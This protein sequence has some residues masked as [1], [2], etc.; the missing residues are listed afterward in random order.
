MKD[1]GKDTLSRLKP[2]DSGIVGAYS[3]FKVLRVYFSLSC[4][5]SVKTLHKIISIHSRAEPV[6]V[7][8]LLQI[9]PAGYFDP[10]NIV[11]N[12]QYYLGFKTQ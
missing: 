8:L 6:S 9:I 1:A 7:F 12:S 11:L 10:H 3:G 2:R 5:L 4:V